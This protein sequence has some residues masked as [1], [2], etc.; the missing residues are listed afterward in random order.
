VINLYYLYSFNSKRFLR[1]ALLFLSPGI[2]TILCHGEG[3]FPPTY[4]RDSLNDH[5]DYV[6]A[7]EVARLEEP[8][9][10]EGIEKQKPR[11]VAGAPPE[12]R[13]DFSTTLEET[14]VV[15]DV[16]SNDKEGGDWGPGN[17]DGDDDGKKGSSMID[18]ATVDL[19]PNTPGLQSVQSTNAGAYSVDKKGLVTF[20]PLLNFFGNDAILY[21]VKSEDAE[22]SNSATLHIEVTNINDA[23]VITGTVD[24]VLGAVAGQPLTITLGELF[25]E[26]PDN[27]VSELSLAVLPGAGYDASGNTVTPNV[28]FSGALPVLVQV[29]DGMTTSEVYSLTLQVTKENERPVITGQDPNPLTTGQ[30]QAFSITVTNLIIADADNSYPSDF[31]LTVQEGS[32]Y[33]F[34]GQ[35]VTPA[36]GFSG[37]LS[38]SVVVSDGTDTSEPYAFQV[39]VAPNAAPVITGQTELSTSEDTPLA[40]SLSNLVVSDPD[41]SFPQDFTFT[42]QPG[43]NYSVAG[44][45]VTPS[46][47]FAGDLSV[48][49]TVSDGVSTSEPYSLLI[50][51]SPVNDAPKITGQVALITPENQPISIDVSHLVI[52]DPDNT[53][54]VLSVLAGDNY[55][56]SGNLITPSSGF[57]GTL[58]VRVFVSDGEENSNMFDLGI[59]V[60]PT[61]DPPVINGQREIQITEETPVTLSLADLTVTDADNTYPD[62]FSLAVQPGDNYTFSGTTV[63]PVTDFS[64]PLSVNLIVNDGLSNSAPFPLMIT[65]IPV[66]DAPLITGQVA[67][68]TMEEVARTVALTDLVVTDPDSHYPDG[69]TLLVFPGTNYTLSG[70]TVIPVQDFSGALTVQVQVSDGSLTS[71]IFDLA[72][73]VDPVNDKPIITGQVPVETAEDTPITIQLSHLTVLDTDS[74]FPTGFT[75]IVSPGV[76][77][78]V[79]GPT[80]QPAVDFNGTLNVAVSVS[81]GVSASDPFSF[82]IQVGNANDAPVI[83]G[84]TP[85]ATDEE[86]PVTL[87]LSN[88]TV[89]DP[90]NAFPAGFTLLISPGTNYIVSG[91]TITPVI[92]FAGV[93]TIPVR[94]ND[95]VNNS[96]TFDFQLQVNQINDPPSFTAIPNQQVAESSPAG[97]V[98]ITG[99]SKGPME[100]TQ[101]LTFIATSSNTA[102][103]ENPVV[104]YNGT[105][106]S[107]VLSYVIKSN[108]SGVATLTIVAVDNGSNTAPN[109]NSYSSSFQVEVLEINTAP[110]L[111]VLNNITI[112]EDA[113]QQNVPLSGISA[114]PGETQALTITVTTNK[115]ELFE[116]LDV[117]Y[118][119]A[120]TSGLLQFKMKANAFGTAEVSVTV[121]DNG[122]GAAPHANTLTR[123]FSV[124]VQPVNDLPVFTTVP[125]TVAVIGEEYEYKV[126]AADPDGEKITITATTKPAWVS[127]SGGNNGEA[128]VYGKPPE[129]TLGNFDVSLQAKDG[130]SEVLQSYSIY[131][132]AR[133]ELVP[134]SV[135][136]EEDFA[137]RFQT[138]FFTAGYSDQNDNPLQ[139]VQITRLPASGKLT[140]ATHDVSTGDTIPAASLAGLEYDPAD[141]FFG[142]DSFG[143]NAFDGYH[144]SKAAATVTIKV[145]P[146]N[147]PP[148][149]ILQ[150]DTLHY[151]V[152]GESAFL[153]PLSDIS[154]PDNDTLTRASVTFNAAGY[155]P[156]MDVLEFQST[157]NIRGNFDFRTGI[158]QYSGTAS[159]AEYRTALRSVRYLHLNTIDPILQSKGITVRLNDGETEGD[160][161]GKVIVLQYTFIEFEIPSGFTPNGDQANDTWV[162]DRPGGGL[163]E[164]DN[165]IICVYDKHGVLVYRANGFERPWDGTMNG[166]LLPADTYFFTIDLQ[167]RNKKTYKGI[168]NILR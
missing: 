116:L 137:A 81:D 168:V 79:S 62:G 55:T 88:L 83:T 65:V 13:D 68:S 50:S 154:D 144:F 58:T 100:E 160:G 28:N 60:T 87:S 32:N 134:L 74:S 110:T 145:L 96:P 165:A 131:V 70:N 41:S 54:F 61:N 80:V 45:V 122:P 157:S 15:T 47:D 117:A 93:L 143:W 38:V 162:I 48:P 19:D 39:S 151:E 155:I 63:T 108:A 12:A 8:I 126:R 115:P 29:S 147:D 35:T 132:N 25:V 104:Q 107:A 56:A 149:L 17:G 118:T 159:L 52:A 156:E 72:L 97:S 163:D 9:V 148:Q 11:S 142:D 5:F 73:Q 36:S 98:T 123:K 77:Y 18:P 140:L 2:V 106:A 135:V 86:K 1:L 31:T 129:G 10:H 49:V 7:R 33:T 26:D 71:N 133:P 146:V 30:D 66:N 141:N 78:T 21:T 101:Q 23:P 128:R 27:G 94:V 64:G 95:G 24:A 109:Q 138:M 53:S 14:P 51:V 3:F 164:M 16:L 112:M 4:F 114:G 120:E 42:L 40:I 76:N 46:Q 150:G 43:S 85:L 20:V 92:N 82:Q 166:A 6:V 22:T 130:P 37:T 89:F 91:E 57:N 105:G 152:N 121:T 124:I 69:F 153:L 59:T 119:G 99:I 125:V 111:D 75:L 158:L 34:S 127:L 84:Q 136:T 102:L 113:E 90:D 161:R 44:D 139:A 103:I 67:V 167:L